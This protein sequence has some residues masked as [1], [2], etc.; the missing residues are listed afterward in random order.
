[1]FQNPEITLAELPGTDNVDW[2]VLDAS[3]KTV[4]RLQNL[5]AIVIIAI[6]LVLLTALTDIPLLPAAIFWAVWLLVAGVLLI[7]PGISVP[8]RA[9][10]LRNNDIL[11]RKGVVWRSVTAIPFNRIQHVETSNTP[12]DRKYE[13]ATLQLFTAGGSSGDLKIDGLSEDAAEQLRAFILEKAGA[14]IEHA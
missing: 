5:I 8:K 1:M 4:R 10:V 9:Y 11:F 7:W 14:S 13:L 3:Y 2:Q 6:P 12:F